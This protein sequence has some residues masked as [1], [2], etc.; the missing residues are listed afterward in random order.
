M[1]PNSARD[2]SVVER[3]GTSTSFAKLPQGEY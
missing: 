2:E 3:D 1:P